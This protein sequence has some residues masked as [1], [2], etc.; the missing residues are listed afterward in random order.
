[1]KREEEL[2]CCALLDNNCSIENLSFRTFSTFSV[3]FT[4]IL[5]S[6]SC[7]IFQVPDGKVRKLLMLIIL[8]GLLMLICTLRYESVFNDY[9]QSRLFE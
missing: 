7:S 2:K 8:F 5:Y 1:M 3:V 9:P 4:N 6:S